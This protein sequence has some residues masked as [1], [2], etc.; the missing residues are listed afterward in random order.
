MKKMNLNLLVK[1]SKIL[2]KKAPMMFNL[3][4]LKRW[5][6]KKNP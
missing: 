2:R 1:M 6:Q 5:P 3:K 4:K